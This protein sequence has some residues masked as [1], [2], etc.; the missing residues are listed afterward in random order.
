MFFVV[1]TGGKSVLDGEVYRLIAGTGRTKKKRPGE[2]A[3]SWKNCEISREKFICTVSNNSLLMN[4][5]LRVTGSVARKYKS[6]LLAEICGA[7]ASGTG[8]NPI[9][10]STCPQ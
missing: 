9:N 2:E 5:T 1:A 6:H 3:G 10:H 8:K 7:R 4:K